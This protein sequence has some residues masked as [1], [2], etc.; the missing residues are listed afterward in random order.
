MPTLMR[1]DQY[2]LGR[3]LFQSR[4][5]AK[6]AVEANLVSINGT[7]CSKPSKKV[8]SADIVEVQATDKFVSRSGHKL[9]AA[10]ELFQ[11]SSKEQ[12]CLDIGSSTGGF[13]QCLLN[14][15][16]AHVMSIDVGTDQMHPSISKNPRVELK[17]NTDFRNFRSAK[18]FTLVVID[19]SFISL[20]K[21]IPPLKEFIT[22]ESTILTLFKPQFEVGKVHL[23][24]G[25]CKHPNIQNVIDEFEEFLNSQGLCITQ[26]MK[27]PLKG[28]EG[29]QEYFLQLIQK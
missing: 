26:Q 16:A 6:Q 23:K 7:I 29:N 14:G 9:K 17:E 13:T 10:L 20:Q 12:E 24:K 1:L 21:I 5:K 27:V 11:I 2:L 22:P 25:I 4:E 8:Q 19:V 15:G 18:R 28:K 3:R